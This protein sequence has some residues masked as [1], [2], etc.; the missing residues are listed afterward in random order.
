MTRQNW[1]WD[2]NMPFKKIKQILAR[3]DDPR[4]S[5]IAGTLLARVPDPKQVFALITPTAFCRRYQAIENE[6]KLDEWTKERVAFWKATY[7][8]LSKELQEKGERIRKPEVVELDDFDRV[9]IEKV[10][11]CRK[12]AAMSQKELAQFMGYSQQFISGIETGREKITMDFLK[13]LAQITEQR[14]DLTVEKASKS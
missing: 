2:L 14:I 7:L 6:I 4:F 9:L 1:Y 12:A 13:K 10:K 8:R 5:R 3:E 11:Q